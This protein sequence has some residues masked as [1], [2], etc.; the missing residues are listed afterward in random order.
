MSTRFANLPEPLTYYRRHAEQSISA[1]KDD[2]KIATLTIYAKQIDK[3]GVHYNN[4]DLNRHERLLKFSSRESVQRHTGAP[5]DIHYLRWANDWLSALQQGNAC[6]R[7]YPEPAF[8]C[9]LAAC[10]LFTARKA[11][12][13]GGLLQVLHAVG[14]SRLTRFAFSH[15]IKTLERLRT[16]K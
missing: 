12:R 10:W 5:L 14:T 16:S 3:L 4:A 8:S 1:H 9:L 15:P 2:Q 13:Y 11:I 7:L 6:A